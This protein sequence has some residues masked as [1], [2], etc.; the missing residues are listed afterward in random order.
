MVCSIDD[1]MSVNL[2]S[3][4][5]RS[6]GTWVATGLVVARAAGVVVAVAV[7]V[8]RAAGVVVALT[9]ITLE[10]VSFIVFTMEVC[11][12]GLSMVVRWV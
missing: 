9:G 7:A 6:S 4:S 1:L 8:A 11:R 3:R 10:M 5:A 12:K 2:S